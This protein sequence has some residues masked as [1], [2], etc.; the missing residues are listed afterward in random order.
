MAITSS[1]MSALMVRHCSKH[2]S[3]PDCA[4]KGPQLYQQQCQGVSDVGWRAAP[5]VVSDRGRRA[6]VSESL[7][8]LC[9]ERWVDRTCRASPM[10]Q[11]MNSQG[12]KSIEQPWLFSP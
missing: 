2:L 3:A 10:S 11:K 1:L 5:A 9:K 8:A 6:R 4:V 7:P 12:L